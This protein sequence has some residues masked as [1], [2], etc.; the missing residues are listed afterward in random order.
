MNDKLI[1]DAL[2]N[3]AAMNA[4]ISN[5]SWQDIAGECSNCGKATLQKAHTNPMKALGGLVTC[6]SCN[7]TE[8]FTNYFIKSAFPIQKMP[9]GALQFYF[10]EQKK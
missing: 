10:E 5:A 4:L 2:G 7:H 6:A 3:Q 1:K 9:E 8:S